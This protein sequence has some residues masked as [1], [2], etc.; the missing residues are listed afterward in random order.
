M[1]RF[2]ELVAGLRDAAA[3]ASTSS[4]IVMAAI[5]LLLLGIAIATVIYVLYLGSNRGR[6]ATVLNQRATQERRS[7]WPLQAAV[8]V[9]FVAVLW[10]V[11]WYAGQSSTCLQCHTDKKITASLEQSPHNGTACESCH[12]AKGVT[13]VPQNL[14][15]YAR[16]VASYAKNKEE[17][18]FRPGSVQSEACLGC[19]EDIT[20]GVAVR[21]GIRVRHSDFL[22]EGWR[23]R[24]CHNSTAHPDVVSE[25]SSPSMDKCLACHN[26]TRASS[27]CETCHDGGVVKTADVGQLP[28]VSI[29][30]NE[31]GSSCYTCHSPDPCT[32]CHGIQMPH[33][34]N[35]V[36][37]GSLGNHARDGFARRELCWRCHSEPG[38]PFAENYA[39]CRQCHGLPD[40]SVHGDTKSWVREHGLQATGAKPGYNAQC[41]FCHSAT[42]CDNCHEPSMRERYNPVTG[43]DDYPGA[44]PPSAQPKD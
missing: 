35:W 9:S 39:F 29:R 37:A 44:L 14:V 21:G 32:R 43:Y 27:Q 24:D 15:T 7:R 42:L 4:R 36:Q 13:A 12:S 8:L 22:E 33:P 19:H 1:S 34:A 41:F 40:A 18:Q 3:R 26:G 2:E 30:L 10:G 25:P 6:V 5:I 17:V 28:K 20:S 31:G 11:D 23:C 16:W 38:K